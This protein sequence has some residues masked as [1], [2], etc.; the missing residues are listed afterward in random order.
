MMDVNIKRP[1]NSLSQHRYT[2]T[3]EFVS[4]VDGL[5]VPVCPVDKVFKDGQGKRMGQ[6]LA[7]ELM[8]GGSIKISEA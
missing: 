7:W 5:C 3:R 6:V 2:F 4:L 1:M 8:W